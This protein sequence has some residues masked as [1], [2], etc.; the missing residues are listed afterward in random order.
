M[1]GAGHDE[2]EQTL[3]QLLAE[4]DGFDPSAGIIVL[5]ATNR[6]KFLIPPFCAQAGL[7]ARS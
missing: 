5:A 7:I 1:P 4:M 6:L 3:N 2:K